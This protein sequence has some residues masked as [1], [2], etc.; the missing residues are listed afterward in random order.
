MEDE[1][2]EGGDKSEGGEGGD[3][4]GEED[5]GEGK[6][7]RDGGHGSLRIT[8]TVGRIPRVEGRSVEGMV[9]RFPSGRLEGQRGCRW[10]HRQEG[11]GKEGRSVA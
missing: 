1:Q 7:E 8:K 3:G 5:D 9:F 11:K 2:E 10:W 4:T 6:D